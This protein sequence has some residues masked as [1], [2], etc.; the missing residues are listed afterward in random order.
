MLNH[1]HIIFKQPREFDLR[2]LIY[3]YQ[4]DNKNNCLKNT[5]KDFRSEI[6]G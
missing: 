2:Y 6:Y 1:S 5:P 4:G 3:N